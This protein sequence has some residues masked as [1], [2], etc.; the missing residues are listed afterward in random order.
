MASLKK[1]FH[2][3][4][5]A[6]LLVFPGICRSQ[7]GLFSRSNSTLIDNYINRL[8][9]FNGFPVACTENGLSIVHPEGFE[10]WRRGE[11]GFPDASVRTAVN[12]NGQLWIGTYGKGLARLEEGKW[13]TFNRSNS[14]LI[15]DFVSCLLVQDTKLFIGTREGLCIYNGISWVNVALVEGRPVEINSLTIVG[16]SVLAGTTRGIYR[17]SD[18]SSPIP[19]DLGIS[20]T[21][22]ITAMDSNKGYLFIGFESGLLGILPDGTKLL[23]GSEKAGTGKIFDIVATENGALCATAHGLFLALLDGGFSPIEFGEKSG[24]LD[25]P[26]TALVKISNVWWMGYWGSG[27]TRIP[28]SLV[29]IPMNSVATGSAISDKTGSVISDVKIFPGPETSHS[30]QL[31]QVF[32]PASQI[33]S[34][35]TKNSQGAS[36]PSGSPQ[37]IFFKRPPKPKNLS[38]YKEI[39]PIMVRECMPCHTGGKGKYFPLNDPKVLLPYFRKGGMDRLM[40]FVEPGNGMAGVISSGTLQMLQIWAKE[41]F[42]E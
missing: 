38:F 20:P 40:Q 4:V 32:S 19:V 5:L 33:S 22:W 9:Q 15:D 26:A 12:F 10:N 6:V 27:I 13:K 11:N 23:W 16:N 25:L 36:T 34:L 24:I 8:T 41:G 37:W 28:D 2:F 14:G 31:A 3:L 42:K 1:R 29:K 21:P 30:G 18:A 7:I 35:G 17:I 39:L